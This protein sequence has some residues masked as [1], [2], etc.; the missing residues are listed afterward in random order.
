MKI[1]EFKESK[2]GGQ[3]N[4]ILYYDIALPNNF[5][6]GKFMAEIKENEKIFS[7]W[8]GIDNIVRIRF[9]ADSLGQISEDL[10][11]IELKLIISELGT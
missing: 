4:E 2:I 10:K 5:L 9:A 11:Q 6:V 8:A 3:Y 1:S 7:A